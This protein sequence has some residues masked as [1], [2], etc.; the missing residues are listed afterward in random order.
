[1]NKLNKLVK[2]TFPE[3]TVDEWLSDEFQKKL[4]KIFKVKKEKTESDSAEPKEVKHSPYI[5]F[6]MDERPGMKAKYPEMSA[7]EITSKLGEKWNKYKE[8]EPEHL[9]K[10]YGYV[11]KLKNTMVPVD[12]PAKK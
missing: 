7:K 12:V 8:S 6:C 1:M 3:N 5:R 2:N 10:S 4:K 11:S 9:E